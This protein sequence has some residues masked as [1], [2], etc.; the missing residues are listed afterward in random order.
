MLSA[1]AHAAASWTAWYSDSAVLRT[2][3][4][5][6]H[7]AG[8]VGGGGAAIVEDRAMLAALRQSEDVR[9]RRVEAQR[10]AH[11]VVLTGLAVAMFSGVLLF[12][13]DLDTYVH[14]RVFWLKMALVAL[15]L[16]NGVMLTRAERAAVGERPQA[17]ARLKRG[18]ILSLVLWFL[19]TLA[20]AALPNVG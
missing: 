12:A 6:A 10:L 18:A 8:L 1:L 20:G 2:A 13:A 16:A 14:S 9:R 5:F 3:I 7:I 17:W 19:T 4:N 11:R 15:L